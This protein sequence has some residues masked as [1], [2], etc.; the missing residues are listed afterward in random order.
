[1]SALDAFENIVAAH[2]G[3]CEVQS[4]EPD[5]TDDQIHTEILIGE[6]K[7]LIRMMDGLGVSSFD[8][9]TASRIRRRAHR[10][11]DCPRIKAA[12]DP[13]GTIKED[14][15]ANRREDWFE[16][17]VKACIKSAQSIAF[18]NQQEAE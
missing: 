17:R 9:N 4:I 12:F 2:G 5:L 8:M 14:M 1:M 7:L 13:L 16:A 15:P 10:F 6:C 11:L 3:I 18:P